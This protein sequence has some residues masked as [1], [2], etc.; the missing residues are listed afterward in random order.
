MVPPARALHRGR[1]PQGSGGCLFLAVGHHLVRREDGHRP[2]QRPHAREVVPRGHRRADPRWRGRLLGFP[3]G[4][5]P[6][7]GAGG[8]P[9][10]GGRVV[11]EVVVHRGR[12]ARQRRRGR[13]R[14][15]GLDIPATA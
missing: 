8:H 15:P 6:D 4:H 11:E 5:V 10:P 9:G 1:G 2:V 3:G 7:P 12:D 14:R 13:G